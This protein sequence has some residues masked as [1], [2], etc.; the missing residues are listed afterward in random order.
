MIEDEDG[1]ITGN[2]KTI[3]EVF[4]GVSRAE[5]AKTE[6]GESNYWRNVIE[7]SSNWIYATADTSGIAVDTTAANSAAT[8]VGPAAT[9][10][11]YNS[12]TGG[13]NSAAEGS[14]VWRSNKRI[15]LIQ[16]S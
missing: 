16:I 8:D 12:L 7:R 11:V 10:P 2:R 14:I 5:D 6:S 13:L 4:E 3:L 1:D 15:R 9:N